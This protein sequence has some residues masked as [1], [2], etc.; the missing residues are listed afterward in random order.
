[1]DGGCR[2]GEKKKKNPDKKTRLWNEFKNGFFRQWGNGGF[3]DEKVHSKK[4]WE[5]TLC[6]GEQKKKAKVFLGG[7]PGR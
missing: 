4:K 2:G 7:L 3:R 1:M 5:K 6:K